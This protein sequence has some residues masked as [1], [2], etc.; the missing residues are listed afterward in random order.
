MKNLLII[1]GII[2]IVIITLLIFVLKRRE[3][4]LADYWKYQYCKCPDF[5]ETLDKLDKL[6]KN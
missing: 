2:L 3:S 6:E 4:Y 1:Y 5:N